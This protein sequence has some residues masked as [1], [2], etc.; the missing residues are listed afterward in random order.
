MF[1]NFTREI[2]GDKRRVNPKYFFHKEVQRWIEEGKDI[3]LAISDNGD[4]V[5][6]SMA[7]VDKNQ[8]LT[9]AVY[10]GEMAYVYPEYRKT[11]AAFMLYKNVVEY[12]KEQNL[13]L[14]ANGRV[15]NGVDA[16]IEKHFDCNKTFVS[17]ERRK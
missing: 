14:V 5:G 7:F 12:A 8:F 15:E 10:N 9:E 13:N 16:M 11:R 2:F 17:Y 1:Y 3:V 4:V 6:Y